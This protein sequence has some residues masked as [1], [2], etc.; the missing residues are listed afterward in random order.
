MALTR[1]FQ[2]GNSQAVRLPKE[3][4][5]N[6]NEVEILRR[7]DEIVLRRRQFSLRS[8]LE[9]LSR[10][11]PDALTA[12]ALTAAAPAAAAPSAAAPP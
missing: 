9:Q 8:A 5:L 1:V 3:F 7:G 4:R 12:A 6:T 2:S 11:P 10:L